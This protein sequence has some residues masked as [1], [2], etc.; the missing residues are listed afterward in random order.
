MQLGQYKRSFTQLQ[1]SEDDESIFVGS[2]SGDIAQ[3]RHH[4]K[5]STV[6]RQRGPYGTILLPSYYWKEV[7]ARIHAMKAR[8]GCV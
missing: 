7:A 8:C 1:I 2:T 5:H 6:A 3:A 4:H